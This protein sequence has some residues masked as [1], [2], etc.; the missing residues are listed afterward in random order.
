MTIQHHLSLSL[1]FVPGCGPILNPSVGDGDDSG[2]GSSGDDGVS[3]SGADDAGDG[4]DESD[5]GAEPLSACGDGIVDPGEVCDDGDAVDGN[6]CNVDCRS[7]GALLWTAILDHEANETTYASQVEISTSG[8][9]HVA[10][11]RFDVDGHGAAELRSYTLLGDLSWATPSLIDAEVEGVLGLVVGS[12]GDPSMLTSSEIGGTASA[13]VQTLSGATGSLRSAVFV[14]SGS[15]SFPTTIAVDGL[16]TV[17]SVGVD[18][19]TNAQWLEGTDQDGSTRWFVTPPE[20][21]NTAAGLAAGGAYVQYN[22]GVDGGYTLER[23]NADGSPTWSIVVP[24]FGALTVD[25]DDTL[26]IVAVAADG[27][28]ICRVAA[29]GSL[30]EPIVVATAGAFA[31]SA[32]ATSTGDLIIGG[33]DGLDSPTGVQPWIGRVSRAGVL[34][35]TYESPLAVGGTGLVHDIAV[36]DD[37][38]IVV[39]VMSAAVT[40]TFGHVIALTP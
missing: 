1:L 23:R 29:D 2:G 26:A 32:D 11:V 36:D 14:G 5:D 16:D 13:I 37:L 21:V 28:S 24:C 12:T 7:S 31:V 35:W 18:A 22:I 33:Y 4:A 19:D 17:M 6:G 38:G 15:E 20:Q 9:I 40:D 27:L 3:A 8:Q 34:E 30:E 10:A 25:G 39:A